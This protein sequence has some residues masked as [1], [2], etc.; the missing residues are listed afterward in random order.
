MLPSFEIESELIRCLSARLSDSRR[1]RVEG[2][3]SNPFPFGDGAD[4]NGA[5][6]ESGL[7]DWEE[8]AE[9]EA[10][11]AFDLPKL[12]DDA[13][14]FDALDEGRLSFADLARCSAP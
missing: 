4:F 10:F 5:P 13:A 8:P 2:L 6:C 14:L 7:T 11:F 1:S 3:L 9:S 12:A